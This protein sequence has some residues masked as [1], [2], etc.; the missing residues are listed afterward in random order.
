MC[1]IIGAYVVNSNDMVP[2]INVSIRYN[3][4]INLTT[5]N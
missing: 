4:T 1:I 2:E 5:N 3:C